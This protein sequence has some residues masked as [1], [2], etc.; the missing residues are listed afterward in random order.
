M[1]YLIS[2]KSKKILETLFEATISA[3]NFLA[4]CF[5]IEFPDLARGRVLLSIH[6]A[7]T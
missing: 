3:L 1:S 6:V 5:E 7:V 4:G 2:R